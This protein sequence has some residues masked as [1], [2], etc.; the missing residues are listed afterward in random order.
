MQMRPIPKAPSGDL[1]TLM[2]TIVMIRAALARRRLRRQ[3]LR[4]A[5]VADL[6]DL[7]DHLLRD[8]GFVREPHARID[9]VR[10]YI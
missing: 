1:E 3:R 4:A 7:S 6:V 5:S 2:R 10:P 9:R 8:M